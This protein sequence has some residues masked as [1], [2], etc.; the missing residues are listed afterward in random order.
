MSINLFVYSVV[1]ND[2]LTSQYT[3]TAIG[4]LMAVGEEG[5]VRC[6]SKALGT[7]ITDGD[8]V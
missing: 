5:V 6:W 4:R 1:L 3:D 2:P 7:V 8:L